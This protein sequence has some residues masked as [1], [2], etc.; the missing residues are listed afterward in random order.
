MRMM[1][2][3]CALDEKA[4]VALG[5]VINYADLLEIAVRTKK[6]CGFHRGGR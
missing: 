4:K 6:K 1:K 5:A 3:V 2:P